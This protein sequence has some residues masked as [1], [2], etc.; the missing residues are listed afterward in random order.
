MTRKRYALIYGSLI[1]GCIGGTLSL[2]ARKV[3]FGHP[4]DMLNII[5]VLILGPIVGY[6]WGNFAYSY[7]EKKRKKNQKK[8]GDERMDQK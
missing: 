6:I 1:W 2:L 4:L 7:Y 3:L 5:T 8:T